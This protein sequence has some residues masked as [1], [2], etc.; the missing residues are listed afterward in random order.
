MQSTSGCESGVFYENQKSTSFWSGDD[1]GYLL[2][3][4]SWI[5]ARSGGFAYR[6]CTVVT[7]HSVAT[8]N[9]AS[10]TAGMFIP[11]TMTSGEIVIGYAIA[12]S[13][14]IAYSAGRIR[15]VPGPSKL[16]RYASWSV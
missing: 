4:L 7:G 12:H 6:T 5:V 14:K 2:H 15:P 10:V 3:L 13:G 9:N 8:Y 16:V 11:K 1:C